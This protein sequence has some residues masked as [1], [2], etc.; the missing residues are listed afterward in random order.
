M[1]TLSHCQ[2]SGVNAPT[3]GCGCN[4][5][6]NSALEVDFR[7][8]ASASHR[9]SR[10]RKKTWLIVGATSSPRGGY[11]TRMLYRVLFPTPYVI[12]PNEN[13]QPISRH[14]AIR[15]LSVV[16]FLNHYTRL[17][18]TTIPGLQQGSK[19]ACKSAIIYLA[20]CPT[21]ICKP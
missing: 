8:S 2:E 6:L 1:L 21:R 10:W 15:R 4:S 16:V 13:K 7:Y 5:R 3:P 20:V 14:T 17:Y 18:P 9:R 19:T 12:T 11:E